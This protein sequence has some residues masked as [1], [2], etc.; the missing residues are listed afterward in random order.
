MQVAAS[1]TASTKYSPG[2]NRINYTFHQECASHRE[3]DRSML[4]TFQQLTTG[5]ATLGC[6]NWSC[7]ICFNTII[8]QT[9]HSYSLFWINVST[10]FHP[11]KSIQVII[12][13]RINTT[14]KVYHKRHI[15][16]YCS[17]TANPFANRLNKF[18]SEK[19]KRQRHSVLVF[20][21]SPNA[22]F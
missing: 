8:N 12:S 13:I 2:F 10:Q 15:P 20:Y 7:I 11:Y 6:T 1:H 21:P 9:V 18:A 4:N 16:L 5:H 19:K 17:A 3:L 14:K 22:M